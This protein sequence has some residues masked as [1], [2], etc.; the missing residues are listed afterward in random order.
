MQPNWTFEVERCREWWLGYVEL[1]GVAVLQIGC[2]A[3]SWEASEPA[4]RLSIGAALGAL[5]DWL[6]LPRSLPF[7]RW[8]AL[9]ALTGV[10]AA[11]VNLLLVATGVPR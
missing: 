8:C 2:I 1:D 3:A 5:A 10:A 6:E 7:R 4:A 9:G 11:V